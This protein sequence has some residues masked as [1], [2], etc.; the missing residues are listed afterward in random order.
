MKKGLLFAMF[1]TLY[2]SV[3]FGQE[4]KMVKFQKLERDL[5]ARTKPRLDLNENPC[6]IVKIVV[7]NTKNFAFEGNLIGDAIYNEGEIWVYMTDRTRRITVKNDQYGVLRFEFPVALE[8]QCVYEM[9]VKLVEDP[10]KK[11]R[12]LVMPVIGVG[13]G[14]PSYG[15]MLGIVR[16]TGA[17]LK[18][19]YDFNNLSTSL[20]CTDD[21]K[22]S[23]TDHR[24]WYTG[25]KGQNRFSVTAGVLQRLWQKPAYLYAGVGYGFNKIGWKTVE[26]E[27]AKN[28]DHSSSGIEAEL[29]GIYRF[30]DYAISLGVQT[31]QFKYVEATIG[32]GIMF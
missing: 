8:K 26:G 14:H 4:I 28:T 15:A 22:I 19:K 11:I 30:K 12:T 7:A 20:E 27:W 6:A 23:G 3:A 10:E 9:T 25:E 32:I 1:L 31:N 17:Y 21:N 5:S 18:V 2:L 24:P 29:G 16:N 13:K